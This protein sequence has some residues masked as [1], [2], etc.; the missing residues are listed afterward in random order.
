MDAGDGSSHNVL[1]VAPSPSQS[2]DADGQH[3]SFELSSGIHESETMFADESTVAAAD[4]DDWYEGEEEEAALYEKRLE[5]TLQSSDSSRQNESRLGGT[6]SGSDGAPLE[7]TDTIYPAGGA[8]P[9][10]HIGAGSNPS[11][12]SGEVPAG[13]VGTG[14]VS[15]GEDMAQVR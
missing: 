9:L 12:Q 6:P 4:S 10:W 7:N 15:T 3:S 14:Y 8:S 11:R 1:T 13:D 5:E 2:H